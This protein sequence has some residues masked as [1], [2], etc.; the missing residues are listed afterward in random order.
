[1][2]RIMLV[3]PINGQMYTAST[4]DIQKVVAKYHEKVHVSCYPSVTVTRDAG[5]YTNLFIGDD[6]TTLSN[7]EARRIVQALQGAL[8]HG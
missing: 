6:K 1:M 5:D 7:D 8:D 4:C 2:S 3:D